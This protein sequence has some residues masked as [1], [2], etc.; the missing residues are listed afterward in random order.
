M[1]D[2]VPFGGCTH[3]RVHNHGEYL[4]YRVHKCPCQA[5]KAAWARRMSNDEWERYRSGGTDLVP[6]TDE[7]RMHLHMIVGLGVTIRDLADR[8]GVHHTTVMRLVR[9]GRQRAAGQI[10]DTIGLMTPGDFYTR[11]GS[12]RR[13][14][15]L[16]LAG[17]P[18]SWL[19]SRVGIKPAKVVQILDGTHRGYATASTS[20]A[21]LYD[22][23]WDSDPVSQGV[24]P[25]DAL[26]A[27]GMAE[28]AGWC[29]ALAWD[30]D[31]IDDPNATPEGVDEGDFQMEARLANVEF[32]IDT[33]MDPTQ[34]L[35]QCGWTKWDSFRQ[36]CKRHG[37]LDLRDKAKAD[38]SSSVFNRHLSGSASYSR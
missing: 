8:L 21:K 30:D 12:S 5:C 33:G 36:T 19:A 2:K 13:L 14:Q 23:V 11:V 18:P 4:T 29:P 31:T 3:S 32:L 38:R 34:A 9:N 16:V 15:A 37:R 26:M 10:V 35:A 24:R 7:I 17:F 27:R 25:Q 22:E 6:V 20:I 28:K 1:A